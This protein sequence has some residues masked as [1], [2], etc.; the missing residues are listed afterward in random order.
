[1]KLWKKLM[2]FF[3]KKETKNEKIE[4]ISDVSPKPLTLN[5]EKSID[6]NVEVKT[7][8][9]KK[10]ATSKKTATPKNLKNKK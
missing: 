2:S 7:A 10:T 3:S 6:K 5:E 1:M 8:T 9:P 4:I